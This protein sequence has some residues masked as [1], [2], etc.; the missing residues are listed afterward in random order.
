MNFV[1]LEDELDGPTNMD[2]DTALLRRAE[3]GE[4][5]ARV[6]GWDGPWV[7]LGRSQRAD[8]ALIDPDAIAHV[9][10][11][12]GGKAVLHGHDVTV[13]LAV[14]LA[15]LGLTP[16]QSR[17]VSLVYRSL[18]VVLVNALKESGVRAEL[19]E[20]TKFVIDRGHT[21]DCFAHVAP[22]DV[23]DPTTG[24][25]V[26]GCALQLTSQAVLVQASIPA[27]RPLVDP[28]TIFANPA[29]TAWSMVDSSSFAHALEAELARTASIYRPVP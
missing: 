5:W 23:V 4:C 12:T 21:A 18:I 26:C 14:P 10:R 28:A 8:R 13:G 6:Y 3:G 20:N 9:K 19:G 17:A 27:R 24:S 1:T 7:S 16:D 25:K 2:R 15:Q 29:V 11:P 22:N